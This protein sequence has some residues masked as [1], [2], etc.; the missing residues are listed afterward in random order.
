[1]QRWQIP[2]TRIVIARVLEGPQRHEYL[3]SPCTVERAADYYEDVRSLPYRSTSP[4]VSEGLYEWYVSAPGTLRMAYLVDRLLGWARDRMG[5]LVIWQWV[6]LGMSAIA[7][8]ALVFVLY[9]L[10]RRRVSEFR[11]TNLFRYLLTLWF[12]ITVLI[13]PILFKSFARESLGVRGTPLYVLCF[14]SNVAVLLAIPVLVFA[15][16]NRVAGMVI[17]S[18]SINPR[19]L[20]AQFARIVAK[21]TAVI[22]STIVLLEGG[23]SLGIPLTTLL[24]SSGVGEF[25]VALAAQDTLRNLFG[26]ITLM[27]DKPFRVGK[28]IIIDKYDGVVEE[29]G[30]RSIR[31]RLLTGHQATIPN[32]QLASSDIENVGRRPHI[33]RVADLN[34]PL[35][36]PRKKIEKALE[37][38]RAAL[39]NHEGQTPD[40]PPRVFFN[41]ISPESLIIRIIYWYSPPDYW[42][43]LAFSEKVNLEVFRAFDEQGVTFSKPFRVSTATMGDRDPHETESV[44]AAAA[45]GSCR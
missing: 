12:P 18:P 39:E 22:G 32:D 45:D 33:R 16:C 1:M 13:I 29:I 42:K 19:G 27:A 20:D 5:G 36:T 9:R 28:R 24:A 43:F 8:L 3:F 14:A 34:V 10:Q 40:F 35:D 26:T 41:E 31:I 44:D 11:E 30:L 37:T 4:T 17:S 15:I 25:A 21:L 7:A 2:G 23:Q 38:I 6:G